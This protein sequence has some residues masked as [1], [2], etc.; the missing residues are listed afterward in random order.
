MNGRTWSARWIASAVVVLLSSTGLGADVVISEVAWSGTA[1]NSSDEWI[2][3]Y[4]PTEDAVDL[5]GWALAFGETVIRLGAVEDDTLAIRRSTIAAGGYLVLERT[6][7][8]TISDIEADVLYKGGLS[9]DGVVIELRNAAGEVVD[10]VDLTEDGWPGGTPGGGEPPYASMERVDPLGDV[11]EWASNDGWIRNGT[12]AN[13]DPLNGTPGWENSVRVVALAAP[14]I[15]LISPIEEGRTLSGIVVIEW[16]AIDPD[17]P[18]EGLRISIELS[19]DGGTW[20]VLVDN[21]ANGGSYAWDTTLQADSADVR[22][23][24]VAEDGGGY[25]GAAESPIL[26]IR[27]ATS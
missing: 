21:L 26:T 5:T 11:T 8:E 22:V 4:N 27:N 25:R 24:V 14:R 12:D 16:S 6:D 3:L 20:E 19:T 2:E 13:G 9:N 18:T 10:R 15:E 17:G 1:A 23:R 7:D